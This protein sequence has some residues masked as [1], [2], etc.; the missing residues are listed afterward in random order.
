MGTATCEGDGYRALRVLGTIAICLAIGLLV[1]F[2]PL[3]LRGIEEDAIVGVAFGVII[4]ALGAGLFIA[5][6]FTEKPV[7][8]GAGA[9]AVE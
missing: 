6:R 4:L 8:D 2:T 5:S 7:R 3:W 1:L 9:R